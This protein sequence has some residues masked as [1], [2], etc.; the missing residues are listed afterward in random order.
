[1]RTFVGIPIPATDKIKELLGILESW[2]GVKAVEPKNIHVTLKFMG[3][4]EEEDVKE[5]NRLLKET[6]RAFSPFTLSL[7]GTGFF[8]HRGNPKVVWI[9]IDQ[10]RDVL[11]E[12]FNRV[13]KALSSFSPE[14][15]KGFIPHVTVGRVKKKVKIKE[16][17]EK[18]E[19]FLEEDFG[20]F[21]IRKVIFFRS[22]L[23]PEGP[24]YTP[25]REYTLK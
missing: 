11:E 13:N 22:K 17:V 14:E 20:S 23:T 24:I 9:G 19:S 12:M 15:K 25:L 6:L 10:G 2:E 8:P 3:N 7:K 21:S 16:L 1:M 4:I 18:V 5:I